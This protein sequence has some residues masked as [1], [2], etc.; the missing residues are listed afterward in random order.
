MEFVN[1]VKKPSPWMATAKLDAKLRRKSQTHLTLGGKVCPI[2]SL[3][4]AEG[5]FLFFTSQHIM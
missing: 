1:Y 4:A 2:F 3:I 5:R